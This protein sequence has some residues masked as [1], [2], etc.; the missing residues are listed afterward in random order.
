PMARPRGPNEPSTYQAQPDIPPEL[1]PRFEVIRAV[2][3]E[4]TTISEAARALS[5]AR[6]NMQTLVH[7]AEAAIVSSLQP[8]ATGPT[9]RPASEKQLSSEVKRL[10]KENDKL[11]KQLQTADEMMAAAGEIIRALRGL[12]PTTSRTS[13][14]RSKRAPKSSPEEDPEPAPSTQ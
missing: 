11:K 8:R 3:G 14:P 12:T 10:Q 6:V 13:S 7:R 2:L 9:A 4:R 5:I 1:K